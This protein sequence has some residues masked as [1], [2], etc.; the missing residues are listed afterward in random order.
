MRASLTL[1]T[2]AIVVLPTVASETHTV[3]IDGMQFQPQTLT[4]QRGD[5]VVW[6][7]KDIVPH[8][9]TASGRFESGLIAAGA[10]WSWSPG[11]AGRYDYVCT[12]HPGMKSTVVVK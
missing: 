6:H 5:K 8:T 1:A 10:S 11:P 3:L 2:L 7:N 12:F 4:V 9:V